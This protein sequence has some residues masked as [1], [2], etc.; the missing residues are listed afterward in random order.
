MNLFTLRFENSF[1]VLLAIIGFIIVI[2]AQLKINKTYAIS[3]NIKNN[4]NLSGFEIARM[5]LDKHGLNNMHIVAVKGQLTDHYDPSR[6]VLRLS[7]EIFNGTSIA[8]MAVSAHECG[9]AIQDKENYIFMR[10]RGFLV[11][12]VN[13]VSYLGYFVLLIS[14]IAGITGYLLVGIVLILATL[15]FQIITLPVEF[16]A[17]SRAEQ[18]LKNLNVVYSGEAEGVHSMLSAA[19]LTYVASVISSLLSLL[20]LI[21]IFNNRRD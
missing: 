6:K 14:I 10:I 17:S 2:Y 5:I 13:L 4:K 15:V 16:D 20:R 19:A 9:H 3:K 8:A 7:E 21:L 1:T 12:V 11:P 18:E